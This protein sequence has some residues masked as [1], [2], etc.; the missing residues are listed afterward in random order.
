MLS[1]VDFS[2][3]FLPSSKSLSWTAINPRQVVVETMIEKYGLLEVDNLISDSDG[4]KMS[5]IKV[6]KREQECSK[7]SYQGV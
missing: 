5:D 7:R 1:S 3:A 6:A 2:S 4:T